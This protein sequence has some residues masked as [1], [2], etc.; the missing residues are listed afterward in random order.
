MAQRLKLAV[1]QDRRDKAWSVKG[2]GGER[3]FRT[4]TEAVRSAAS[5]GR[6]NGHA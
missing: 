2:G 5:E 3:T 1:T 6:R 4:K